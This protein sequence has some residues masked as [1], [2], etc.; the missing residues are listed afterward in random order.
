VRTIRLRR[1][2]RQDAGERYVSSAL[3]ECAYL[4]R[5]R[6]RLAYRALF[7]LREHEHGRAAVY[8]RQTA[9]SMSRSESRGQHEGRP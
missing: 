9:A 8:R 3:P 6:A 5:P 4:L 1:S 7:V 2:S